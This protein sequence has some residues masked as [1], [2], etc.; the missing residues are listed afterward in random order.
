MNKEAV[1]E[2]ARTRVEKGRTFSEDAMTQL[3]DEMI[4]FVTATTM[5]RW[6]QTGEPPT[7]L[8]VEMKVSV[9]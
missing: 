1:F 5:A 2:V 3:G 6:D 8:R 7:A 9:Q 4:G